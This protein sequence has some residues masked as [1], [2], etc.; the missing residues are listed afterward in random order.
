M[1]RCHKNKRGCQYL[2]ENYK[3]VH[4]E[5]LLLFGPAVQTVNPCYGVGECRTTSSSRTAQ[6]IYL[7][8]PCFKMKVERNSSAESSCRANIRCVQSSP[9]H[10]L[11]GAY[12]CFSQST[13]PCLLFQKIYSMFLKCFLK[14][15][16]KLSQLSESLLL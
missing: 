10:I 15:V 3:H 6:A 2:P 14:Q 4:T 1:A 12:L 9:F 5:S 11:H 7:V 13:C 16:Y 8:R